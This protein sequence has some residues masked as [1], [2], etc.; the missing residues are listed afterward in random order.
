MYRCGDQLSDIKTQGYANSAFAQMI[1]HYKIIFDEKVHV[2]VSTLKLINNI[3]VNVI[4][5]MFS[6]GREQS[7]N[8]Q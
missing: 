5:L 3:I 6:S 4:M 1:L 7:E 8:N 2:Q